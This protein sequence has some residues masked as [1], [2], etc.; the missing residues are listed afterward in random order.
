MFA[1]LVEGHATKVNYE[2]NGYTHRKGYHT[3][4]DIY[5]KWSIFV[6]AIPT[7]FIFY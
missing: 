4:D 5:L 6:K 2:I 1:R 3:G 7:S